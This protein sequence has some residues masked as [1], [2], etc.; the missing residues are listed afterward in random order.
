MISLTT[1]MNWKTWRGSLNTSR[2]FNVTW[3]SCRDGWRHREIKERL[4]MCR[5]NEMNDS[6]MRIKSW[7]PVG[8]LVALS[9]VAQAQD[10]RPNIV[11]IMADDMGYSDIGCYGGEIE[12]PNLDRLA[13]DGL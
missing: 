10:N 3:R 6:T 8:V 12:T 11:L 4:W 7:F 5:L 1:P 9:L 13:A 2:W